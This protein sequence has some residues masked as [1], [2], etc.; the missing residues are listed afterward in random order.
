MIHTER[1]R[2]D[3][4]IIG[5][6]IAGL[7]CALHLADHCQVTVIAKTSLDEGATRWAQGGIAAVL[8]PS[9][10][11]E[12]HVADTLAAGAGLCDPAIVRHVSENSRAMI[13]WLVSLGVPF[14]RCE[15]SE[16]CPTPFHLT[17]EGGHSHRRVIHVADHTG[18]SVEQVLLDHAKAHENICLMSRHEAIDLLR[19][20][21]TIIGAHVLSK[22]TG[23]IKTMQARAV[24]LATGGASK[25]YLYTSNPDTSTGDGIAMA[26]RAGCRVVNME[27]NQFH[28]TCLYHPHDRAFLISEAVRGEGGIL[29]LPWGERF[30]HHYD[31]RGELAPRD[32]VA[33]AIDSELK[34]HG[35]DHVLLDITHRGP[36]FIRRH[37]PTIY[38][39]L[40][41]VGI[42]MTREPIPVVPA[43]HYTCGGVLT[44][45]EARTDL[46]GLWAVGETAYTGLHGANR[47]ASN[48]LLEG[49]VFGRD[50]A[51]SI[52]QWLQDT[53]PRKIKAPLWDSSR[54]RDPQE[55]V[56][57][58]HDWDE[59]RR[60]MWDYV[61]IVRSDQRLKQAQ[62]RIRVIQQEVEDYYCRHTVNAN[63]IELRNLALVA[64][65]IILSA[66]RRKES[67][68]LHYNKDH[69]DMRKT[70]RPTVL[71]P[72]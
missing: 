28:P 71:K 46:P 25:A 11:V 26:W 31:E 56:L 37:F 35:I 10:S 59:I 38:E 42:D 34:K 51:R 53:P 54:A 14:S 32:I 4:L 9:D 47:L 17:Q 41:K 50:A 39:R 23:T 30:M 3:V 13:D 49:L 43:A 60:T 65:L 68:G 58:S 18:R 72:R 55:Q 69:P 1:T 21:G 6:G 45:I 64:E 70:A 66:R 5:S 61:G 62:K 33:R 27:F 36:A 2:T 63:L 29:R 22:N 44:D 7:T 40:L 48:S 12:A 57:I 67:R 16:H 19:D 52:L 8:D 24:V 20:D 15:A